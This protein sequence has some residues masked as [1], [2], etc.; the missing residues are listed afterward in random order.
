LRGARG[1]LDIAPKYSVRIRSHNTG[2]Q[3][4]KFRVE[5]PFKQSEF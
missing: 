4:S 2:Q 3:L 5:K 1:M